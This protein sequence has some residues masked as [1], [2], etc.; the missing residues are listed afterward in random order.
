MA[1]PA[2]LDMDSLGATPL[3]DTERVTRHV[4]R[5]VCRMFGEMGWGALIEFRLPVGRRVDVI[6]LSDRGRFA[7][8]E[9]KSGAADFRA[10]CKWLEYVPFCE[11]F[12]FA[13]PVGF[14]LAL[15]PDGCGL[16]VAD[17]YGAA[18]RRESPEFALDPARK[19]R[20]LVRFAHA[21]SARLQR[22]LDPGL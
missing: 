2:E 15:L 8:V 9:V 21:A 11:A 6:A 5:G 7:I 3:S 19:R 17:E 22:V 4:M 14:P 13:V 16:I 18:I 20:Q 1:G 10:D 12:Y